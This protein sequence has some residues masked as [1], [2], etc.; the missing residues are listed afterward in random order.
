MIVHL[1]MTNAEWIALLSC[2]I[3]FAALV[4]FLCRYYNGRNVFTRINKWSFK[5]SITFVS[6]YETRLF[7]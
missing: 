1:C 3:S 2:S 4:I 5:S 6:L 7:P